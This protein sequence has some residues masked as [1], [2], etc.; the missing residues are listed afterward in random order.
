VIDKAILDPYNRIATAHELLVFCLS[1]CDALSKAEIDRTIL[2]R[3]ARIYGVEVSPKYT[4]EDIANHTKNLRLCVLGTCFLAVD[5]A[6]DEVFGK[7]P[8]T[9]SDN[10]I[11]SLR[12]IIYMLRCAIAHGIMI[13][14]WQVKGQYRRKFSIKEIDYEFDA[15][16]LDGEIL[17]SRNYGSLPGV[18][19]LLDYAMLVVRRYKEEANP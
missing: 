5:E 15:T 17:L 11:D 3:S 14:R 10:D 8:R 13:P 12:A 16:T 4:S 1:L 6:L 9:F 18:V 19:K 2:N 7:K